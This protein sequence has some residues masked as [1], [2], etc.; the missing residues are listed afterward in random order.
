MLYSG[1]S[2]DHSCTRI[3]INTEDN[4][5]FAET[6]K[7]YLTY[8]EMDL[9]TIEGERVT[10]SAL[11]HVLMLIVG[12]ALGLESLQALYKYLLTNKY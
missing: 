5:D 9:G 2:E 4:I 10:R 11:V 3:H 8:H 6:S 7:H 1:C 12:L